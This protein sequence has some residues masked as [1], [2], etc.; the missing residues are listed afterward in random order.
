MLRSFERELHLTQSHP[1]PVR[2]LIQG[3]FATRDLAEEPLNSVLLTLL[4]EVN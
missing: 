2:L 1:Q 3:H 4:H